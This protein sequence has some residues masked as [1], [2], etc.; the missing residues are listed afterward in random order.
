MTYL[1]DEL[2]ELD[3]NDN[4]T[5]Y[6]TAR[7]K[8]QEPRP[9]YWYDWRTGLLTCP[10][11]SKTTH[12]PTD[13]GSDAGRVLTYIRS[14]DT[15]HPDKIVYLLAGETN[16]TAPA[17]DWYH[18]PVASG[19][20]LRYRREQPP[21]RVAT[22]TR[23]HAR[24]EIAFRH[25]SAWF[26]EE[27]DLLIIRA[28]Y[29]ALA[30]HMRADYWQQGGKEG[31]VFPLGSPAQTGLDLLARALPKPKDYPKSKAY[32]YPIP[33]ARLWASL[34]TY[35]YQHRQEMCTD[36]AQTTAP[37][38]WYLDG[39]FAYAAHTRCLPYR[40]ERH[41]TRDA[42]VPDQWGWY[43]VLATVPQGWAHLG[44]FKS[45]G[46]QEWPHTPGAVIDTWADRYEVELALAHGWGV[47]I[48]ERYVFAP[49]GP[50]SDPMRL[51]TKR[52]VE[53]YNDAATGRSRVDTLLKEAWGHILYDTLGTFKR[54]ATQ[55]TG[56]IP[57][58]GTLPDGAHS[59]EATRDGWEYKVSRPLSPYQ[60]GW[61]QVHW[62]VAATSRQRNYGLMRRVLQTPREQV[63]A[64]RTDAAHLFCAKPD[65]DGVWHDF[66]RVGDYRVKMCDTGQP[67]GH[68]VP[69]PHNELELF[70][71]IGQGGTN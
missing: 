33:D 9:V 66:G 31:H 3:N 44:I 13:D 12:I 22:Y 20:G 39:R 18:T 70:G 4:N 24:G 46:A 2:V 32:R 64:L 27:T 10:D 60:L 71:L 28:A 34:H 57:R 29:K 14:H 47:R 51:F 5:P 68:S 48:V 16:N 43:H 52:V 67:D 49:E 45:P 58:G 26:R 11:P 8:L 17:H 38:W 54:S 61:A 53:R 35:G 19:W 15:A 23:E 25:T 6:A 40:L 21:L 65:L 56:A 55:E 50:G 69:L 1:D 41:D 62:W 36:P 59:V 63:G 37:G 42:F 7:F 30:E